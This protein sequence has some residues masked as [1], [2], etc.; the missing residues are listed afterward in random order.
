LDQEQLQLVDQPGPDGLPGQVHTL[1]T[2]MS[3]SVAE[4]SC[5]AV[6]GSRFGSIRVL[7]LDTDL[8]ADRRAARPI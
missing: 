1:P 5:R 4:V 6:P 3:C 8:T 7:V 2:V